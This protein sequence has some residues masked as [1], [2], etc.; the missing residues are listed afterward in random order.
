MW[1]WRWWVVAGT[2]ATIGYGLLP[3]GTVTQK[4][5]YNVI[6]LVSAIAIIVAVRLHRPDAPGMWYWFA[7]G[8]FTSTIGDGIFTYYD[9]T[10][11]QA[12]Y[13]SIADVIY[14]A[15]YPM[16]AWGLFLLV[17]RRTGRDSAGLIDAAMV[18]TAVGLAFW[19][20]VLHPIAAGS[21]A[22]LIE[23][24]CSLAY[25]TGDVLLVAMLARTFTAA[26]GR[27]ASNRLLS[28]AALLLFA[29][30]V[31]FSLVTLHSAYDG[32][33]APLWLMSYVLWAAAALHP[34]MREA[35]RETRGAVRPR[36]RAG[37][38]ALLAGCSLSAPG[39]LFVPG[40]WAE[41]LDRTAV[42]CGA[43]VLITLVA[44]RLAGFVAE[45]QRQSDQ[46]ENLA[47]HDDL[48]GLGNRR[49]FDQ[50]LHAELAGDDPQVA[51]LGLN[52]FKN[53]NDELGHPVGD[54]LLTELAGRLVDAAGPGALV[55]RM[56]GDE[57]AVLLPSATGVE[58]DGIAGRLA[59]ALHE[60]IRAGGHELLVG[61]G[62]GLADGRAADRL[63]DTTELSLGAVGPA[64]VLRRAGVA[65][66]AA[67]LTGEPYRRWTRSSTNAPAS[68]PGSAPNCAPPWTPGSSGSSTSRSWSCRP[69]GSPRSR[70][71]CAGNI[72]NA[73]WSVPRTS[74]RSPSRTA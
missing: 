50:A 21:D 62:I 40:I 30:D 47:M 5:S 49:R 32:D 33:L 51:L 54:R 18:T 60:P 24:A 37:R 52:N 56:S 45:V 36:L 17:R 73:A 15:A 8:Q 1:V 58:A 63:D 72:R 23:R 11:R 22:S 25:P 42:G 38:L 67:K 4:I 43:A 55:A 3:T 9:A 12:P 57:F 19:V 16:L 35:A 10:G 61:A 46:L 64:E 2:L 70:R 41:F 29:A 69:A 26:G 53:I 27:S 68:T 20:F 6:G 34:S 74:S 59:G 65:M 13:P 39:L 31:M 7:A 28:A 66:Y 14:L 71:W 44:A 48:T